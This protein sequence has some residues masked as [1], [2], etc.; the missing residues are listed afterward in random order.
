MRVDEIVDGCRCASLCLALA[1]SYQKYSK[2]ISDRCKTVCSTASKKS[3]YVSQ[4][5]ACSFV[6]VMDSVRVVFH[7]GAAYAAGSLSCCL[8]RGL[9]CVRSFAK[10]RS[11]LEIH[12]RSS[13]S[14]PKDLWRRPRF[15]DPSNHFWSAASAVSPRRF[16]TVIKLADS[17]AS[18][19][20]HK[21]K[22]IE[23]FQ[24]WL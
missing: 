17:A 22:K 6:S 10:C 23:K 12:T 5:P 3:Q 14:A 16:Q 11:R 15:S 9:D 2:M 13:F 1:L 18:S 7:F 4:D 20:T 19:M 24:T 21:L 8:L